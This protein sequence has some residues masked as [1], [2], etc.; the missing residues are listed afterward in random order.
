M[1]SVA[2]IPAAGKGTRMLPNTRAYPKELIQFGEKPVIEHVIDSLR[3]SGVKKLLIVSG[4]KKSALY[5]YVGNGE[6]FGVN[7]GYIQQERLLGLGHAILCAK[8]MV[9]DQRIENFVV[10]LGDTIIKSNSELKRLIKIHEENNAFA[11]LLIDS[12]DTPE[13][14]GVVKFENLADNKGRIIDM[15]EKPKTD[16]LK[17]KFKNGDKWHSIAGIY[18]FNSKIF[19]YLEKTEPGHGGEIQLT[20]AIH[21]GLKNREKVYGLVSGK[22]RIDVGGWD[23]L[24]HVREYFKNISDEELNKIIEDRTALMKKLKERIQ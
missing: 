11:T 17:E 19:D 5:D 15:F 12:V 6:I 3:E 1:V 8:H 18:I 4:H 22:N 21:A 2:I 24:W 16:E 23:Y 20:D 9:R 10:F 14:Y 7:V 13:R